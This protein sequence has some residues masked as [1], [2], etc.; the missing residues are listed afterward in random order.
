MKN[1]YN[2]RI[3]ISIFILLF[4]F[5]PQLSAQVSSII[6]TVHIGDAKEKIPLSISA[7]L[8]STESI[9]G[10]FTAFRSFGQTEFTRGEMLITGNTASITIPGAVVQPPFIEYYLIISMKDGSSQTYPVGIEQ[11]VVP[12]Q[13]PVSGVSEKDKEIVILSPTVGETMTQSEMLISISFIN[14]SDKIDI[15]KTKIYLNNQDVTGGVLFAGDLL[16]LSGDNIPQNLGI[17]SRLLKINVYDKEGKLYNSVSR[18]FRIVSNEAAE[19]IGSRFKYDGYLKEESRNENFNSASVWYN[20]IEAQFNSSY[21]QWKLNGFAYLTSE[22]K[23]NLQPY[24]RYSATIQNGDWLELKVGD[25]FP[26]FPNLIID[27]KR[28]RGISGSIN[29]G[30]VNIQATYGQT[31]REVE[32]KLD[33]TYSANNVPL[34]ANI[35]AI[36]QLKY[37]NP[38]GLVNL[39]TYSRNIFA[40]RPSFGSGEHFQFGLSYLHAKDDKNSIE[41][42][43]QPQENVT[44]GTDL[45]FALDDQNILFT[46]QA[47]ISVVNSDISTGTISDSQ[48]DSLFGPNKSFNVDPAQVKK[49]KNILN[50]F[51]TVNQFLGPWNPQ[52]LSSFAADAALSLNYFDNQLRG[53]YIYRGNDF[54]SFGQSFLRT[55]VKGYNFADRFRMIDNKLFISLGYEN[56][57]DNLQKTKV[58]TTTFKTLSASVSF[59]PRVD[60]PNITIGYNRY[61]NNNGLSVNL[62]DTNLSKYTV[63]DITNRFMMQCSYDFKAYVRQSA[64]FSFTTSDRVD[65]GASK[66]NAK[67][68]ST[69]LNINSYWNSQLTSNFGLLYS[70]SEI[71][72]IPFDY[73]SLSFGG[74]YKLLDNKLQLSANLSPSFGDYK[75]QIIEVVANYYVLYNL[76]LIFQTRVYRIPGSPTNSIVGLTTRLS[77]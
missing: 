48:I 47:A 22:E 57:Q 13:V 61:D 10:I 36:D 31:E 44:F 9:T 63:A 33:S 6:S 77:I 66:S 2:R 25:A 16:I 3:I 19:E 28:V 1:L 14:A 24:D 65:N 49:I 60:F 62:P 39:G 54:Q 76:N 45:K 70:T 8:F 18:D 74:S 52:D 38:Y 23:S 46:S 12:L 35:I 58:A 53:L 67:F 21:N 37:G 20:N 43:A 75:R 69:S 26:Q 34:R 50:K 4:I 72:G 56:L 68:N 32:G 27:G 29:L 5:S 55:D 59:F 51:I 71:S 30:A 73:V 11:G 17:G 15:P 40:V 42:G 41:F 64:S 7:E